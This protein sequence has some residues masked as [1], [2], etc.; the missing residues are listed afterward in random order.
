MTETKPTLT[1]W[2]THPL[3]AY[4]HLHKVCR[5]YYTG[6]GMVTEGKTQVSAMVT[7]VC[8]CECHQET[9]GEVPVKQI[10]RRQPAPP[11]K[12]IQRRR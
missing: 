12:Y 11:V 10:Q 2:C 8:S 9:N 6:H 1:G 7:Y 3:E 4:P 5:Q